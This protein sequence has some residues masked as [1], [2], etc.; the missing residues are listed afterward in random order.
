MTFLDGLFFGLLSSLFR[1]HLSLPSGDLTTVRVL[2]RDLKTQTKRFESKLEIL[3]SCE[4]SFFKSREPS[5]EKVLSPSS[6]QK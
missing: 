3:Y 1:H 5:S 4:E 2:E 6:M